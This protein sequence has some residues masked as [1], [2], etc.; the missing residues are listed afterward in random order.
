MTQLKINP[1]DMAM[2]AT[3]RKTHMGENGTPYTM[4]AYDPGLTKREKLMFD[5]YVKNSNINDRQTTNKHVAE[6][7]IKA[8]DMLFEEMNK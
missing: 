8:A 4:E 3:Y 5:L 1:H 7:A 6:W 2:P